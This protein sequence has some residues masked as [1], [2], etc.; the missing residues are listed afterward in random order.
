MLGTALGL[1][2]GVLGGY[3]FTS[4]LASIIT[5]DLGPFSIPPDIFIT[6]VIVGLGVPF[7]AALFPLWSGTCVTVREA[8][9]A[10]GVDAATVRVRRGRSRHHSWV[11]QTM[12]L[13]LRSIFRRKGRAILT[14]LALTLS[15]TAFLAIQTTT[16][17]ANQFISQIYSQYGFD[18][19]VATKPL[20]YNQVRA[21]LL[22]IPNV[23]K[24]E[25]FE[26]DE[27]KT[28]WGQVIMTAVDPDTT[29]YHYQVLNGRWL[30]ASDANALL[31][32]DSLAEQSGLR[33]GDR[34]T[35]SSSTSD[36][37]W[38]ILGEVH[39]ANGGLGLVGAIFTTVANQHAFYN[40]PADL[41]GSFM[42]Q[43][44]D[45]SPAA[46]DTMATTI[47]NTL[48]NQGLSPYVSTAQQQIKR[49]QSQFQV[50]YIL[51]YAVAAIVAL[52]GVLG[53][54]NTLVTSVLERRREI[55]ILRSM[56]ATGWR[57][58]GVF[59][60]EGMALAGISWLVA[61]VLG[62]PAAYG[63]VALISAVLIRIP[64]A[65]NP[66][67][68]VATLVFTLVITT[69]ASILPAMGAARI[70]IADTLRYE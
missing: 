27:V 16:Y 1:L 68:L 32:S 33:T 56:G 23:A 5:L 31:I 49:N 58:A 22:A 50:L 69:V 10:Y 46:I 19:Y 63:F 57:V 40:V 4:Y 26:Q 60:T 36:A 34:L 59:W 2:L 35:F 47:D 65:F 64:F 62:V 11:P 28:R 21:K 6:S 53:L 45:R 12:W 52:V 15:A 18:A 67:T 24:V 29:L 20:P 48:S 51:L 55:G 66:L 9:A 25:R 30:T 70:R 7:A 37:S 44:V 14:L 3:L 39:D 61:L 8:M 17:S 41:S 43:A 38:T 13:G 42:I 54:F